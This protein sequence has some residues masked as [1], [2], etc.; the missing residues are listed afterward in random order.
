MNWQLIE[1]APLDA[2][3][4]GPTKWYVQEAWPLDANARAIIKE[5][6]M[7]LLDFLKPTAK[8]STLTDDEMLRQWKAKFYLPYRKDDLFH[9]LHFESIAYGFFIANGADPKRAQQLYRRCIAEDV[10]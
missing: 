9:G 6:E 7:G 5:I 4:C 3:K 2:Y 8:P 10:F 1:T